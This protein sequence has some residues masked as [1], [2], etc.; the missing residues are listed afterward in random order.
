M[1]PKQK[2]TLQKV[3]NYARQ[4]AHFQKYINLKPITVQKKNGIQN[5]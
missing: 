5:Q 1:P 4:K 3:E 2:E